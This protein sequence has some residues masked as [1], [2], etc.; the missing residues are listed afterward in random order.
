VSSDV[1]PLI[2]IGIIAL[3]ITA[4]AF[5][6]IA[7]NRRERDRR[8]RLHAYMADT[9]WRPVTEPPPPLVDVA[10]RSKRTRMAAVKTIDGRD[11]WMVWH[12][13]TESDGD[14]SST[15]NLTRYFL[16][17]GPDY[18][19]VEVKRRTS[20]GALIK[21]VRGAGTGDAAFDRAYLIKTAY[22]PDAHRLVGPPLRE[23]MLARQLPT[24]QI[25]GGLLRTAMNHEIRIETLQ[26]LADQIVHLSR[27]LG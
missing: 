10:V 1:L 3:P 20:I 18:P 7:A 14:S 22:E 11:V 2:F 27:L 19:D 15:H 8:T 26:P 9:G 24:W 13:W 21:P 17:L 12:R 6:V 16:L 23:L 4:V 5:G 25:Q